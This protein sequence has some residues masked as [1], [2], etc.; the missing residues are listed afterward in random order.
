M[1]LDRADQAVHG[2][3]NALSGS[4]TSINSKVW[5]VSKNGNYDV[6][7]EVKKVIIDGT[8]N[9]IY[10]CQEVFDWWVSALT[11]SLFLKL[12]LFCILWFIEKRLYFKLPKIILSDQKQ[13]TSSQVK[14]II[15]DLFIKT[16]YFSYFFI[17]YESYLWVVLPTETQKLIG[18]IV[19]NGFWKENPDRNSVY[20]WWRRVLDFVSRILTD[21]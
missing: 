16:S 19:K 15:P 14:Y 3:L 9:W 12:F 17:A 11:L 20:C 18:I 8:R 7:K 21:R 13:K 1:V 10:F 2:P 6:S 4:L 5:Y